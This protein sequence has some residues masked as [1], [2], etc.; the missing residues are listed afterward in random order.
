MKRYEVEQ[1]QKNSKLYNNSGILFTHN[2]L[3]GGA[4]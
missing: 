3:G 2:F 4:I 1:V